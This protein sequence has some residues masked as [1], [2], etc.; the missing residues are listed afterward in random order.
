MAESS[1]N[2]TGTDD[3]DFSREARQ[4]FFSLVQDLILITI[5]MKGLADGKKT[6]SNLV[7][8]SSLEGQK[9]I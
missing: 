4:A 1:R 3:E 6:T 8:I 2:Q 7:L 9:A 5:F